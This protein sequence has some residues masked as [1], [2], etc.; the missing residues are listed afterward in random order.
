[1][2]TNLKV[3]FAVDCLTGDVVKAGI[4]SRSR[5]YQCLDCQS[6]LFLRE[7]LER[8]K[9]FAHPPTSST[10][11][12]GESLNHKAAKVLL[13]QQLRRD[14][15]SSGKF[16]FQQYCPGAGDKCKL[17]NLVPDMRA[18]E[19]WTGVELE[20]AYLDFRLDV[21]IVNGSEVVF[22]F[23]VY[24]R[25]EVPEKKSTKLKIPWME[26]IADDILSFKPRIPHRYEMSKRLCEECV[27]LRQS[28]DN[29]KPED[30]QRDSATTR[31]QEEA[32][33]LKRTWR[34]ILTDA[35]KSSRNSQNK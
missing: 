32:S 11:C 9:H 22:G 8:Q 17:G 7:G 24:H 30:E 6:R 31:Y 12:A 26:L 13:A 28:L 1:M 21:A 10:G 4:A 23:E 34:S 3:P 35:R 19:C 14:L 20:V 33:R 27:S 29:R 5:E 15:E 18:I 16:H 2:Q 25:H